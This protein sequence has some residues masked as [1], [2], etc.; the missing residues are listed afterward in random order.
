MHIIFEESHIT[1]GKEK[2]WSLYVS[3]SVFLTDDDLLQS[4]FEF[5]PDVCTS[6]SPAREQNTEMKVDLSILRKIQAW[7]IKIARGQ[8]FLLLYS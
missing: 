8:K 1:Y 3:V 4:W 6:W 7:S 2:D 5:I